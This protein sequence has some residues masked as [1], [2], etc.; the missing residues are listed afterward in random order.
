MGVT[1]SAA[2]HQCALTLTATSI[3]FAATRVACCLET[4]LHDAL[5][6]LR[7]NSILAVVEDNDRQL[8]WSGVRL[9]LC[10]S[11]MVTHATAG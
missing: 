6:T 4:D 1:T 8:N 9:G 10:S 2:P 3:L 7:V 11:R 5:V